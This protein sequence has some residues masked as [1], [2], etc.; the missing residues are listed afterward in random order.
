MKTVAF[1]CASACLF[2]STPL[3]GV[4]DKSSWMLHTNALFTVASHAEAVGKSLPNVLV[5]G[6]SI[7]IGYTPFLQKRFAGVANVSHPPCNCCST[8]HYLRNDGGLKAWVGTNR[9]DVITVNCGIWDFCYMKGDPFR[10]DHYWGPNDEEKKLTPLR[11]GAAIRARG[12]HIRTRI[13]EYAENLKRILACLKS[14][15]ATV[16]FALTTPCLAYEQDDRCGLARAYNEVALMVCRELAVKTV[17]LYSVGEKN[18]D[19]QDDGVHYN[20][21]GNDVLAATLEAEIRRALASRGR[22]ARIDIRAKIAGDG[23]RVVGK[24]EW[25]GFDRTIFE[26][27]GC[28]TWIVEPKVEAKGR[29][30]V[31][32]MEWPTAFAKRTGSVALLKAGFHVVTFRP[33][34]YKDGKFESRPGNMNDRRLRE[35]RTFQDY[36]VKSLGFASKGNLIGMSWG[37]F[38]SVR[39]AGT[40][41]ESVAHVYLDAPLLDFSTLSGKKDT[42][43]NIAETYGVD[44]D[45][46][47]GRDDSRQPVNMYGP[48][49]KAKI[50]VLLLYGGADQTVNPDLNCRRFAKS[51]REAGGGIEIV[52]RGPFGHWPHG[53]ELDEQQKFVE[54]FKGRP[55]TI[56]VRQAQARQN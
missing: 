28:E 49:A 14:T 33:G 1:F 5:L 53:L 16:L 38:Y 8:Q 55:Q 23:Y 41:P 50:P 32:I 6:D 31:W 18:Y 54:F 29:P 42:F 3:L 40:Y 56:Q 37:G 4:E 43:W 27:L 45:T 20:E 9:W 44:L 11:R 24:D 22:N 52:E 21:T 12:F 51:F 13:P 10:T 30:W 2:A 36:L 35:S 7:S 25:Y 46:Y 34:F 19:N 39:Y 47:V 26:F 17:D 48:I 15:G